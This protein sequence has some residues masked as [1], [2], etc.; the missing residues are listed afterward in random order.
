MTSEG[1]IET[2]RCSVEEIINPSFFH[3]KQTFL[4]VV[5]SATGLL[6]ICINDMPYIKKLLTSFIWPGF[7]LSLQTLPSLYFTFP[8]NTLS[9]SLNEYEQIADIF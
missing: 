1:Q 7:F 5:L 9:I 2:N 3:Y 6:C 8:E 4:L